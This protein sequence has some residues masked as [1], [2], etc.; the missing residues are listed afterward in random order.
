[1]QRAMTCAPSPSISRTT[2]WRTLSK[3]STLWNDGPRRWLACR[4]VGASFRSCDGWQ[5][6]GF[7]KSSKR[8]GASSIASKTPR[9]S[10]S[11]SSTAAATCR[12][13]CCSRQH[14]SKHQGPEPT[15]HCLPPRHIR[16][17]RSAHPELISRRARTDRPPEARFSI[18]GA[19][20]AH[21]V[22]TLR[23]ASTASQ[24]PPANRSR[25]A[26]VAPNASKFG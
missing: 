25:F 14:A 17:C 19:P 7:A 20:V 6:R 21:H 3:S 10:S 8:P 24:G 12:L 4:P 23:S 15:W 18:A 11:R 5:G 2:V 26:R 16:S 1:M 9:C 13:G 22:P